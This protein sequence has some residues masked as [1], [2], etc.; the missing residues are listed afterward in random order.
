VNCPIARIFVVGTIGKFFFGFSVVSVVWSCGLYILNLFVWVGLIGLLLANKQ[1]FV[2]LSSV[3]GEIIQDR[4]N[5]PA[6]IFRRNRSIAS[7]AKGKREH[8]FLPDTLR[9]IHEPF[10]KEGGPQMSDWNS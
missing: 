8:I 6:L 3:P 4:G 2:L 7:V 9:Y 1:R 10:G 5:D